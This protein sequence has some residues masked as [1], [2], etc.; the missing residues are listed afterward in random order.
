MSLSFGFYSL[1]LKIL[2]ITPYKVLF[3]LGTWLSF[4]L[5]V[6]PN[7]HKYITLANLRHVFPT[8]DK[9]EIGLLLKESLFHSSMAFLESG[10]V[11][12][13]KLLINKNNFI[14]L[15][16]F[17][18]VERSLESR[19]GVLL[20]T[21]HLGNIE[22]LIN[23]LGATTNCT[24]PYTRPKNKSLD[25]IMKTSRDRAGVSMVDTNVSG[26]KQMLLALREGNVVAIA[27]DQVPKKGAGLLSKFF[28]QDCLSMTLLT[29][30]Q[31]KTDC[32]AHL[33]YCERKLNGEGFIIHFGNKID[34]SGDLQ[35]GVDKMNCEFE[36][37]IMKIPG[38]YSWEYKK[39]KNTESKYIYQR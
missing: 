36:K 2:E 6:I 34:L 7:N 37:C 28:N 3:L 12:G 9:K 38:Q 24:V 1:L 17:Q 8:K 13:K 39:F 19:Q 21:P 27:S 22:V 5:Y 20:F 23:H 32:P 4:T 11:W 31:Q 10:L 29:K 26:I 16:N 30:L 35:E 15:V 33:M 25:K 14:E 18:S